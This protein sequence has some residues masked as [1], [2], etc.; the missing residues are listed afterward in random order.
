M[1]PRR[2][3]EGPVPFQPDLPI[4]GIATVTGIGTEN[5]MLARHN[6]IELGRMIAQTGPGEIATWDHQIDHQ[7]Q[8]A[9]PDRTLLENVQLHQSEHVVILVSRYRLLP[10]D[11]AIALPLFA[12]A[13]DVGVAEV[14]G[15][16]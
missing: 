16:V 15:I 14:T 9:I 12:G 11:R 7:L 13:S 5:G 6:H 1:R 4:P 3:V 10:A 8:L 2:E